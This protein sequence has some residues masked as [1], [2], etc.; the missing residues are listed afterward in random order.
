M[1]IEELE[2]LI[3]QP[4]PVN[5]YQVVYAP[6]I[7]V[8]D[9]ETNRFGI[10]K[11]TSR[12]RNFIEEIIHR[13]HIGADFEEQP[14]DAPYPKTEPRWK[15]GFIILIFSTEEHMAV[16]HIHPFTNEVQI[17]DEARDIFDRLMRTE[18]EVSLEKE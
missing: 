2:G 14:L 6:D 10:L 9:A 11:L 8:F 16:G 3:P 1:K 13:C 7:Y 4:D 5:P 18:R 15:H 12:V 17:L